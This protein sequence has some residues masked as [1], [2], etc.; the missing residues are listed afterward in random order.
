MHIYVYIY[1]MSVCVCVCYYIVCIYISSQTFPCHIFYDISTGTFEPVHT[2]QWI[3]CSDISQQDLLYPSNSGETVFLTD[4]A[5]GPVSK[6]PLV[7]PHL[8]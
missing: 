6:N 7:S 5:F 1:Y 4:N 2:K 3:D 8:T